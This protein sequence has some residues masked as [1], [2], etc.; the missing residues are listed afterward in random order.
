MYQRIY[1]LFFILSSLT[2]S[3]SRAQQNEIPLRY[4]QRDG[5]YLYF[6]DR[7]L[8]P[9]APFNN[10][11][12]VRVSRNTSKGFL[13]VALVSR[14]RSANEFKSV[15]GAET[16]D[17]LKRL[18]NLSSDAEVW[19][20]IIAHPL[21]EDYGTLSFN[22]NFR[23][24]MGNAFLDRESAGLA[25]GTKWFYK[26]ETL[27]AR[28][29]VLNA[30]EGSVVGGE[31]SFVMDRAR[32][33]KV[34]ATDSL[35]MASWYVLQKKPISGIVLADVYRQTGGQGAYEKLASSLLATPK[36]DSLIFNLTDAVVPS[37]LYRYYL[38]PTDDIGN[39]SQRSDTLNILAFDF[40]SLPL[41]SE[42]KAKDTINGIQLTW[43]P[44]GDQPQVV[45]IEIQRSRDIRGNY[46]VID[47]IH[48]QEVQYLDTQVLPDIP[49]FYRLRTL[50]LANMEKE[51][52]YTGYVT[53]VMKNKQKNPDP[54]YGLKGEFVNG[55]IKLQWQGVNDADLY[56]YFVYRGVAGSSRMDV[57]SE[58]LKATEFTDTSSVNGR[59]QF[60][61]AVKAVNNNSLTSEF[62]NLIT[63]RQNVMQ[64]P[65]EPSGANAYLRNHTVVLEWPS[66]ARTDY[67]VAGYMVYRREAQAKNTFD[68]K[69]S[70]AAQASILKFTLLTNALVKATTY[71][72]NTVETGKVYEYA[73]ASV[74]V[75]GV[76]STYSPFAKI[77]INFPTRV[78]ATCTVR[79]VSAGVALDWEEAFTQDASAIVIYRKKAGESS[80][81]RTVSLKKNSTQYI[82]KT[83]T[84]GNLYSYI[85]SAENGNVVLAKSE[86]KNIQF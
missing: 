49:Y 35:V 40:R 78:V 71:E 18:L 29:T 62:S 51:T 12:A 52:G 73:I 6:A 50:A 30:I 82:D 32:K 81:Q 58:G 13:Q 1:I 69:Q 75:F 47:T 10:I 67:A 66:A 28:G 60:V 80:Y 21:M 57:I 16:W 23:H 61:Y 48:T 84:K 65:H 31:G 56:G 68:M 19:K 79:K 74:D 63:M 64:L 76:E 43:K 38:I 85:I 39:A 45:G 27:D 44:L 7:A 5:T 3:V 55:K 41:M 86:E 53:A 77:A 9:D 26:I 15:C 20:Y 72:D 11:T 59:T 42:V 83:A 2:A 24:A 17:D 34:D 33:I 36:G 70:A 37:T 54:P 4:S 46:V 8:A 25:I 14:A 22:M